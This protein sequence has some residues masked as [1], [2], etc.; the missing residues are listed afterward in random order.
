MFSNSQNSK[1]DFNFNWS[2]APKA[3][4]QLLCCLFSPKT[5]VKTES[6]P[7]VLGTFNALIPKQCHVLV[8]IL[9]CLPPSHWHA[10]DWFALIRRK[11]TKI[12]LPLRVRWQTSPGMLWAEFDF[13]SYS[14]CFTQLLWAA[15]L[16]PSQLTGLVSF[17]F[18]INL[19]ITIFVTK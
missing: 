8:S 6:F 2:V 9:F 18:F 12:N 4:F 15:V 10:M 17:P 1:P 19:K 14:F 11:Q 7:K 5:N 13:V 3:L 16:P